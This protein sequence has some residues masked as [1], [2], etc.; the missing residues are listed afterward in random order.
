MYVC[1]C[2]NALSGNQALFMKRRVPASRKVC[3]GCLSYH[4]HVCYL[5]LYRVSQKE[6][7]ER[8]LVWLNE[9]RWVNKTI[10]L[11]YCNHWK[12]YY[13]YVMLFICFKRK[14]KKVFKLGYIITHIF[15]TTQPNR[16]R[17]PA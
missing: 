16:T 15:R 1:T 14:K 7:H 13:N 6:G 12:Y 4:C 17:I 9:N 3:A 2:I 8:T 5:V 10:G 11:C